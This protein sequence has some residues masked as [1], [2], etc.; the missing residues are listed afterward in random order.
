MEL[1]GGRL[2]HA[3]WSAIIVDGRVTAHYPDR[4]EMIGFFTIITQRRPSV[5]NGEIILSTR[6]TELVVS[7]LQ[8]DKSSVTGTQTWRFVAKRYDPNK[9][10]SV[11]TT[12]SNPRDFWAGVKD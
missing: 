1:A 5:L 2:V 4:D 8:A 11:Q 12:E 10:T 7:V 6:D 9:S 3:G